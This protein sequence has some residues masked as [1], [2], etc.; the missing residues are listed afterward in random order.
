MTTSEKRVDFTAEELAGLRKDFP[1]TARIGRRS[2]EVY[3]RVFV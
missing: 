2:S 1:I 3:R